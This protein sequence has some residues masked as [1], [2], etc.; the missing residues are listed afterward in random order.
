MKSLKNRNIRWGIIGLG[1]I[2][3]KFATDLLTVEGAELYAVAS[4]TQQKSDDFAEKYQAIKAYGSYEALVNDE[5]I[6]A[7]YIATPHSLHQENTL[8]CL[9]QGKAVL[10]EKPFAMNIDEVNSMIAAATKHNTLL[11]EG[12]WTYFLPHYNF[13]LAELSRKTYG[14]LLKIEADFGFVKVFNEESR[15]FNKSLGGG[16]LLDIGIYPI[17]AAL[18]TLGVPDTI[19]AKASFFENGADSSCA[20]VFNYHNAVATLTSTLLEPTPSEAIFYCEQGI[21]KINSGFHSP[22]TVT[23]IKDNNE[24]SVF[25]DCKT[26]GYNY[27]ISHF[28]ELL[29]QGKKESHIMTFNF[30]RQLITTLDKV[31]AIID[32]KY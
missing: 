7:V 11:M 21:I 17:F 6:D 31:R 30:S 32:L 12:L 19:T 29:R 13:V 15:L 18:S 14:N 16:S 25:F 28:N 3:N 2:A 26:H 24:E 1:N 23:L 4:R 27:Q 8:L 22:S 20:M 10:C 5:N 9:E